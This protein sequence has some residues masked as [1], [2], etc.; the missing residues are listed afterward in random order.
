MLNEN[1]ID[2]LLKPIIDRQENINVYVL[3]KIA[4]KIK[5]IGSL[6][7]SDVQQLIKLRN[8]AGDVREIN[9]E[10]ARL[11]GL[12]VEEIKRMIREVALDNYLDAKPF[13]DYRHKPFIPFAENKILQR[14]INAIAYQTAKTY[15]NMSNAQ[16]FMIRDLKNPKILKPTSIAKTYQSVVDEA[17][18]MVQTGVVDY[19][20]AMRRTLSQLAE[21]G[22]RRVTYNTET[23][24]TYTQRMDTAVRR[25]LLDGVRAINQGMQD[26]VGKQ[27]DADGVEISVHMN[28][29]EDHAEMQGHQYTKDEFEKMQSGENF[30]DVQGRKY[31]GF[32]RA[33]GTLNCRHFAISIIIG[34]AK[35]NYTDQQLQEILDKNEAGYIMP[36]GK[37]LTMYECTQYQ[38]QLE[39]KVRY[40]KD[41]Q[42]AARAADDDELAQKYQAKINKYTKQYAEFSK[43]CG[44]SEKR[45][46]TAVSGYRK[47]KVKSS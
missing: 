31:T 36:N 5:K 24:R 35:Q 16:A 27:F 19:Q 41:G 38:R 39:T 20:T 23:G 44:L 9:Q 29:A 37:H 28:P 15:M 40:A 14:R 1:A 8:I 46:K 13:Y 32:E 21:S 6:T 47:I 45:T 11:T 42:I 25:N 2:K 7:S 30:K 43:A 4:E 3:T 33:V 18:Q 34:Y 22:L 10:I 12:N 17:I 26:E